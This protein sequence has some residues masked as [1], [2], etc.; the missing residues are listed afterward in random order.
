MA[1]T[2]REANQDDQGFLF[3]V[4]ASTRTEEM[5]LVDWGGVQKEAFLRMQFQ[6]QDAYYK[7]NYLG[8]EFQVILYQNKPA[9]RLYIHRKNDEIRIIDITLLPE[10]RNQGIGTTLFNE[11]REEA[12]KSH[13]PVTIHVERFNPAQRLYQ[14]LGF[15]LKEDKGVYLLLEYVPLETE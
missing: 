5:A 2:L 6:A 8:A 1:I 15:R 7:E 10:F 12:R 14:R 13:L 11:I 9:G 3:L 4:Y